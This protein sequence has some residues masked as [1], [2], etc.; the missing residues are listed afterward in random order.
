VPPLTTVEKPMIDINH[1]AA[2]LIFERLAQP[3]NVKLERMA[4][5]PPRLI[6]RASTGPMVER[7]S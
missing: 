4:R 2:S 3:D 7:R 1:A 5:V 6:V